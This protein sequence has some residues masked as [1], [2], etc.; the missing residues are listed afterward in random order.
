MAL[1]DEPRRA[2]PYTGDGS[3]VEFPFGFRILTDD[4]L[5]VYT[6]EPGGS[7]VLRVAGT[8]YT[9]VRG[10]VGGTVVFGTAPGVGTTVTILGAQ[11]YAQPLTLVNQGPYFAEDVM[12]A[13]DR[14]TILTQQLREENER[15]LRNEPD[16]GAPPEVQS[17]LDD[18]SGFADA[19]ASS[20]SAAADSADLA[21]LWA[22]APED[23][24]VTQ[25]FFSALHHARKASESA[26]QSEESATIAEIEVSK[27]EALDPDVQTGD[28]E[29][30][31]EVSY[32]SET[33]LLS[34]TIPR[35]SNV[36]LRKTSTHIQW[37]VV[38]EFFW[39]NLVPLDDVRGEAGVDA[40]SPTFAVESAGNR[41]VLKVV[42]WFGGQG[43]KPATGQ[44]LGSS[45]F[46]SVIGNAVNVRGSIGPQGPTGAGLV[47]KG[48]LDTVGDLPITGDP[49][50]AYFIGSDLYVWNPVAEEWDN[51][52]RVQGP[53]GREIQL[54]KGSTSLEYQ[55]VSGEFLELLDGGRLQLA[56]G[57]G[58][59]RF[60]GEADWISFVDLQDIKGDEGPQGPP[61]T[62]LSPRVFTG[63]GAQTDFNLETTFAEAIVS[64]E[65]IMQE[66]G[67]SGAYVV[68]S[69]LVKFSEAPPDGTQVVVFP[70]AVGA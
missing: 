66:P 5:A 41:R 57:S 63:N 31:A 53:D 69:P 51:V 7:S 21:S 40:W 18:A 19:A 22:S 68:D 2:G 11:A 12:R 34:F 45:G 9:V 27:I 15:A 55:Y 13:L 35:G 25:G 26:T 20:E 8:D 61:A 37:R 62:I 48:S 17:F 36:E 29:T 52:G 43:E 47:V 65:G 50:D 16:G 54:R 38:G 1:Y 10:S 39:N 6:R 42:D 58:F 70:F 14:N 44:Y 67:A 4:D 60:L 3:V 24:E 23:Q 56:G 32:N 49:G 33:G 30:E 64:V 59:F 46:T 28:P